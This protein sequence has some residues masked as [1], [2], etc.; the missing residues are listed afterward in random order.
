MV[1]VF[2]QKIVGNLKK[3]MTDSKIWILFEWVDFWIIAAGSKKTSQLAPLRT[4][5]KQYSGFRKQRTCVSRE[6]NIKEKLWQ[7]VGR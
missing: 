1:L 2:K 7:N 3:S 6:H 4:K 5:I